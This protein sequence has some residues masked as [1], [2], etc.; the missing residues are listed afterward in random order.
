MGRKQ[1]P[2]SKI[3]RAKRI[4]GMAQAVE[5][6][7]SKHKALSSNPNKPKKKSKNTGFQFTLQFKVAK[8]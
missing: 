6:V 7:P 3:T 1:N 5:Y 4:G 2:I 8:H